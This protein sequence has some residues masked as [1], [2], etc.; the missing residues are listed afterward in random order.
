M[1]WLQ[2]QLAQGPPGGGAPGAGNQRGRRERATPGEVQRLPTET[3]AGEAELRGWTVACLKDELRRLK[4]L[5]DMRMIYSGGSSTNEMWTHLL[6]GVAVEKA[7]LVR[8][9]LMARGGN[10]GIS[11]AV[12]LGNYES[13]ALLRLLPCGHRFH[14]D[15]VDHW[16]I[17]QSR[18][19]PLCS[20]RV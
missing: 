13:G 18:T 2:V 20:K 7:E 11:C 19:C 4:R 8:A 14:Q 17:K 5:A 9:V 12:C 16:L 15:C 1:A 10:S 6:S 3:F